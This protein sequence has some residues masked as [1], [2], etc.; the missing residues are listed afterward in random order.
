MRQLE[1]QTVINMRLSQRCSLQGMMLS[2]VASLSDTMAK[3]SDSESTLDEALHV[4]L[5][6]SGISSGA[7][8]LLEPDG[9]L[10]L[11]ASNGFSEAQKPALATF[12]GREDFLRRGI[13]AGEVTSVSLPAA[14]AGAAR[15]GAGPWSAV[16]V[17]LLSRGERVGALFFGSDTPRLL[18]QEWI[19]FARTMGTQ[20]GQTIGLSRV[21]SRLVSSEERLRTLMENASDGIFVLNQQGTLLESNRAGEEMLATPRSGMIG[22]NITSY[23]DPEH[24]DEEGA[25]F[26]KIAEGQPVRADDVQIRTADGRRRRV[27]FSTRLIEVAGEKLVLSI[28]HDVTERKRAEEEMR[29]LQTI[30]AAVNRA[31]NLTG[32]LEVVVR[33]V[34]EAAGWAYGEAWV[35]RDDGAVL[36]CTTTATREGSAAKRLTRMAEGWTFAPGQGLPGRVWASK[37]PV[38]V[39]DTARDPNFPRSPLATELGL[40]AVVGV[41]VIVS[42]QVIAVLEFFSAQPHAEDERLVEVV[43][44]VATQIASVI[45]RRQVEEALQKSEEQLRQSQKMDAIG[46]LAGGIAHDFNNILTVILAA[47]TFLLDSFSRSDPRRADAEDIKAGAE[48]ASE[49]TRQLLAFS[50]R[51]VLEPRALDLNTAVSGLEKMLRRLI[52][53]HI[54]FVTRP[55]EGLGTVKADAGQ[56][57]QVIL[58]I[59]VNARDAMPQGGTLTIETANAQLDENYAVEHAPVRPGPY[60]M[61]AISD[62][63]TGMDAET[64]R[65]IFEP[66]FTTKEM[67][68]GTGLG[69]STVYGIV[70]QSGGYVWVYS[71]PGRGTVFKIY[72]PRVE[73]VPATIVQRK[74]PRDLRGSETVLLVEDDE[75]V[76]ASAQRILE[77]A[78][79]QVLV[80]RSAGEAIALCVQNRIDLLLT[81][82]VMPGQSGPEL[83]RAVQARRPE[84]KVLFMS[85]YMDHSLLEQGEVQPGANLIQKPFTP[86]TLSRKV[87]DALDG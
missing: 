61:L 74:A 37:K 43:S 81:D 1:R 45:Q 25:R 71:E 38:W 80:A 5:D 83:A 27:D 76:R 21:L 49:L 36:V 8:Y 10:R 32:A 24:L 66:F 50:R 40:R 13:E 63:G 72:L 41:P 53:E 26:R 31:E 34:C 17:P 69:L 78:G 9:T 87:R 85:G 51:Q 55:G 46:Q 67:G 73:E 77:S 22:R 47:V 59:V 56:I 18:D 20:L 79:Y 28:A 44:T 11:A 58:N 4:I 68:K 84:A 16:L 29:L 2:S 75:K 48:R 86:E 33:N 35:P 7:L 62:T 39:P 52:G 15:E 60:V 3:R 70:K 6:V 57:E 12:F 42:D 30:A 54:E 19:A 14:P 65:R 82:V 23:F 64:Q